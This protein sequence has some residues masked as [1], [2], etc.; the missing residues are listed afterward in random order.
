MILLVFAVQLF[1]PQSSNA[2]ERRL[3]ADIMRNAMALILEHEGTASISH[4]CN[5]S[6][7]PCPSRTELERRAIVVAKA[8][9]LANMVEAIK[10]DVK[11][12]T[13][14]SNGAGKS[15]VIIQATGQI[16]E[17]EFCHKTEGDRMRVLTFGR[18]KEQN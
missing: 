5:P 13:I 2:E 10:T 11:T 16:Y 17:I 18:G 12:K 9:A 7:K 1:N 4:Q 15:S 6:E 3:C 14:V 8:H